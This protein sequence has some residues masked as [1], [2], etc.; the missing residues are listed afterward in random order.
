MKKDKLVVGID[1]NE[2]LRAQWLQF[3]RYYVQEFGEEGAPEEPYVFDYFKNYKWE[4]TIEKTK[5][6]REPGDMPENIN[7]LD[8]QI[9]ENGEAPADA[10]LFNSE[11]KSYTAKENY[12]R[13]MFE[14][15]AF[16]L[17]ATAPQMYRGMDLHVQQFKRKYSENVKFVIVSNEN[18]FTIPST[19]SF[20]STMLCRFENI[21]FVDKS[22][23]KWEGIDI[24]ITADPEIL[25]SEIPEGKEII[26]ILRPFN[27]SSN[28]GIE[29]LQIA[30]LL[31]NK[32]FQTLI[33]FE[34][35]EEN[36]ITDIKFKSR[37]SEEYINKN[38]IK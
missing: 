6:L 34:E 32:E 38:I 4:D 16:E 35:S 29:V 31:K 30:D 24:L 14:D 26:K 17:H 9:D 27:I 13:F 12:N 8:Y 25:N 15:F 36:D 20:L 5:V 21:K 19:L 28:T 33:G 3:D 11:E 10:F 2:V 18:W 7:P 22:E 23:E 37:F 1:I